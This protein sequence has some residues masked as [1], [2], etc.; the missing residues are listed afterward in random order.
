MSNT[1][2]DSVRSFSVSLVKIVTSDVNANQIFGTEI[3]IRFREKMEDM[4]PTKRSKGSQEPLKTQASYKRNYDNRLSR[5][6]TIII[7]GDYVF[8]YVDQKDDEETRQKQEPIAEGSFLVRH[9]EA[10]NNTVVI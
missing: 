10:T 6:R 3:A 7:M 9:V 4:N 2:I 5:D 8:I 1:N